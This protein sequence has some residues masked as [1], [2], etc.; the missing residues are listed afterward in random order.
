MEVG[1]IMDF[2][3]FISPI[4]SALL[5]FFGSYLALTNRIT[6]LETMIETL[7]ERVE[8]HNNVVERT[9]KLEVEVE[10]LYQR[11]DELRDI[12]IGGTE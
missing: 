4:V 8:K 7:S 9:Y 12:K 2:A 1:E 5:A 11:Y 3:V 6:R 10:N